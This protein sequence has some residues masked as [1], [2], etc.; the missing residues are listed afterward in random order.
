MVVAAGKPLVL[1]RVRG[2][3]MLIPMPGVCKSWVVPTAL[4]GTELRT[5]KRGLVGVGVYKPGGSSAKAV[6]AAEFGSK[7][8]DGV[9]DGVN[10]NGSAG[11]LGVGSRSSWAANLM[12][13]REGVSRERARRGKL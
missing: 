8:T 9:S 6:K 7:K 4:A 5:A 10:R 13:R 11:A 3:P 2:V 12:A 1:G